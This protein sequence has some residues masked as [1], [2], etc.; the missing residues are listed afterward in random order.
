FVWICHSGELCIK[1]SSNYMWGFRR[2]S[3]LGKRP[4]FWFRGYAGTRSNGQ[5]YRSTRGRSATGGVHGP[6][7]SPNSYPE[8]NILEEGRR[9]VM[10]VR[11]A[12]FTPFSQ[13]S[14][15]GEFSAH[16]TAALSTSCD[17]DLWITDITPRT[18]SLRMI[19]YADDLGFQEQLRDYDFVSIIS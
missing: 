5:G 19:N 15:V 6:N 3:G 2:H 9:D 16:V 8:G 12:W 13:E 14:A 10:T 7:R 11:I 18:S 4:H 1:E 17:V